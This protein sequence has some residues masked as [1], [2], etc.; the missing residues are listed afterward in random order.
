MTSIFA[1]PDDDI[2]V[3]PVEDNNLNVNS[4]SRL[5]HLTPPCHMPM[6]TSNSDGDSAFSYENVDTSWLNMLLQPA[7]LL[8]TS[9]NNNNNNDN[10]NSN[11]NSSNNNYYNNNFQQQRLNM[12]LLSSP[13]SSSILPTHHSTSTLPSPLKFPNSSTS[14]FN[15]HSEMNSTSDLNLTNQFIDSSTMRQS[16][17]SSSLIDSFMS[18]LNNN[19]TVAATSVTS[20]LINSLFMLPDDD[21]PVIIGNTDASSFRENHTRKHHLIPPCHIP[22][23]ITGENGFVYEN[24][25]T[26]WLEM[27]MQPSSSATVT[28]PLSLQQHHAPTPPPPPQSLKRPESSETNFWKIGQSDV[29]FTFS[30]QLDSS[31][32]NSSVSAVVG[33]QSL[34]ILPKSLAGSHSDTSAA[35]ATATCP[36]S[37]SQMKKIKR[38]SALRKQQSVSI[39]AIPA[40]TLNDE[41]S[42]KVDAATATTTAAPAP[43]QTSTSIMNSLLPDL[44]HNLTMSASNPAAAPTSMKSNEV[45]TFSSED[46]GAWID[47]WGQEV[48]VDEMFGGPGCLVGCRDCPFHND[49]ESGGGGEENKEK[50]SGGRKN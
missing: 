2:P 16:F 4:Q 36:V 46:V 3:F 50:N 26:S 8:S 48:E 42:I 25:D 34:P 20:D 21:I 7:P 38:N 41:F 24:V 10:S 17:S 9:N 44:Q 5:R 49:G 45:K 14:I 23:L 32:S 13:S 12:N 28:I 22:S 6:L 18:N 43:M 47:A 37:S 40:T 27:L 19:T 35:A 11:N 15:S 29:E 1:L 31:S 33:V 30:K 39:S